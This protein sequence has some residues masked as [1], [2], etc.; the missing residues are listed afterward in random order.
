[1]CYLGTMAKNAPGFAI[2]DEER[3]PAPLTAAEKAAI[4]R[5]EADVKAGRL[6]DHDDVA[7]WLRQRAAKIVERARKTVKPR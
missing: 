7:K 1:M 5:A 4:K 6:Y 3:K 2:D